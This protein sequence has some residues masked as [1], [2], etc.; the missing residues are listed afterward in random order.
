MRH[1]CA[2]KLVLLVLF[3]LSSA[4]HAQQPSVRPYDSEEDL[5][6]ALNDDE[7]NF[8]E[9]LEL[10][11]LARSGI[12]TLLIP[13]SDWEALPGSEAGYL[14]APD[15]SQ[16][17]TAPA[18]PVTASRLDLPFL[19]SL[20]VGV[21]ADLHRPTGSDGYSVVRF[22]SSDLRGILDWE[23]RYEGGGR[24]RRRTIDWSLRHFA[25]QLGNVEPRWGRGLVIGRRSRVLTSGSLSGSV[26][27][28][29][30]ARYNGIWLTTDDR[31]RFSAQIVG[32]EIRNDS[33]VER[34]VA[35][36]TEAAMG[37]N[38]LG[39]SV[40]AGSHRESSSN[41]DESLFLQLREE[42]VFGI[43]A[44]L[45]SGKARTLA[46]LAV[47]NL[48]AIAKAVELLWPLSRGQFH[49]RAWSYGSGF[50]NPWGGGPGH[51][52]TRRIRL[53]DLDASFASR[54]TG[55]RG[56]DFT[57]RLRLSSRTS[58]RWDWM[59]HREE[60]G[61]ALEHSGVVRSEFKKPG[62]RTTPFVR[63]RID[64][65]ATESFSIGNYT[66]IGPD[67]REVNVRVEF[68]THY[69]DE[70]QFVR[71]GLGAKIQINRVVRLAPAARW[72]DPNLRAPSDGYWYFYFTETVIP[73]PGAQMDLALA[74]KKHEAMAKDDLV[75]LRVRG[76]VR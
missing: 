20:R 57:T 54:T 73:I 4:S 1:H 61:A 40:A 37:P 68:G 75:E 25:V 67:H 70:V 50:I 35:I 63:A 8:D 43:D 21:D 3:V 18:P 7:I 72:T 64:E 11:D 44:Q 71:L 60:P 26:W 62:F 56:F 13:Q 51:S 23:H 17:L 46:E 33:L 48:G 39:L 14:R 38:R 5:W 2:Y 47:N 29:T 30:R 65:D 10:L 27:Q 16:V 31:R 45:V 28:P 49:A 53:D 55:E 41:V 15:S 69:D 24:W 32:S 12:D 34:V 9:F 52:D 6:E 74:W 66:W 59:S 19:T 76:F 36:R 22:R 42:Q 58:L